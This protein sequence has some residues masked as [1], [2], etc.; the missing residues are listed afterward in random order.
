MYRPIVSLVAVLLLTGLTACGT[1]GRN[2]DNTHV[3]DVRNNVTSKTMIQDWFGEPHAEGKQNG[4]LMWTYQY[5][6]YSIFCK[7]KSKEL[8]LLFG[9]DERVKAYRFSSNIEEKKKEE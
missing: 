3:E 8:I 5:D 6:R 9:D 7:D 2:F 1:V 4:M